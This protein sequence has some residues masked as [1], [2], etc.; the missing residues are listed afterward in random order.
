M[1]V[2]VLQV[3]R[4]KM[5]MTKFFS[6]EPPSDHRA[7]AA[8]RKSRDNMAVNKI[9][10]VKSKCCAVTCLT[11]SYHLPPV[12]ESCSY[13]RSESSQDLQRID[14]REQPVE[15]GIQPCFI[16]LPGCSLSFFSLASP[17]RK[18]SPWLP[19]PA[20]VLEGVC[21]KAPSLARSIHWEQ[22]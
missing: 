4:L 15:V 13:V 1:S 20:A 10:L 18:G 6:S 5:S 12:T 22:W 21:G 14:S 3:C 8:L 19:W 17:A 16:H 7:A 9:C 2:V 11:V